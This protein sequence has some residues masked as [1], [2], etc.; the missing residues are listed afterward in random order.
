MIFLLRVNILFITL[1][2]LL[3][4]NCDTINIKSKTNSIEEGEQVFTSDSLNQINLDSITAKHTQI[5]RIGYLT[6]TI[7]VRISCIKSST[8]MN[9]TSISDRR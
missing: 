8:S 7:I 9:I 6:S 5:I 2:L 4:S 3:F 1:F